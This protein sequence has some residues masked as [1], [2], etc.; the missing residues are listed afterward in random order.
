MCPE[1]IW[2]LYMIEPRRLIEAMNPRD[3]YYDEQGLVYPLFKIFQGV[4]MAP[5]RTRHQDRVYYYII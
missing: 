4:D 5:H 2:L 1:D 3:P